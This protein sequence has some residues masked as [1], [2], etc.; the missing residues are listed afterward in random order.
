MIMNSGRVVLRE[1]G[2]WSRLVGWPVGW[3][4]RAASVGPC[5][6]WRAGHTSQRPAP[7]QPPLFRVSDAAILLSP[8]RR[9][10]TLSGTFSGVVV[11]SRLRWCRCAAA[12]V[13]VPVVVSRLRTAQICVDM[14]ACMQTFSFRLLSCRLEEEDDDA[15]AAA[16]VAYDAELHLAAAHQVHSSC[17]SIAGRWPYTSRVPPLQ[18][19]RLYVRQPLLWSPAMSR[20]RLWLHRLQSIEQQMQHEPFLPGILYGLQ[21]S[22]P[23]FFMANHTSDSDTA[24]TVPLHLRQRLLSQWTLEEASEYLTPSM[25]RFLDAWQQGER[26]PANERRKNAPG[27]FDPNVDTMESAAA[28]ALHMLGAVTRPE[29]SSQ[30]PQPLRLIM[31]PDGQQQLQVPE[32]RGL[33]TL[34]LTRGDSVVEHGANTSTFEVPVGLRCLEYDPELVQAAR[35]PDT[36]VPLLQLDHPPQLPVHATAHLSCMQAR[37]PPKLYRPERPGYVGVRGYMKCLLGM[38]GG[39]SYFEYAHRLVVWALLGPSNT[40]VLQS[41]LRLGDDSAA[42]RAAPPGQYSQEQLQAAEER[43]QKRALSAQQQAREQPADAMHICHNRQ[44]IH[45]WHLTWGLHIDNCSDRLCNAGIMHRTLLLRRLEVSTAHKAQCT[46]ALHEHAQLRLQL[47]GQSMANSNLFRLY[48]THPARNLSPELRYDLIIQHQTWTQ[49]Q[50][51]QALALLSQQQANDLVRLLQ[52]QALD[53]QQAMLLV[54]QQHQQQPA[55]LPPQPPAGP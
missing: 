15:A 20:H 51:Q 45:P 50:L 27:L 5:V 7:F 3:L 55:P 16:A 36:A 46:Q 25:A 19:G 32:P 18:Q 23:W 22:L 24:P 12:G 52:Q 49:Q 54:H 14:A 53:M 26:L 1:S 42:I 30:P 37:A 47:L 39:L 17:H 34:L 11:G 29:C 48:I 13:L 4:A 9:I 28:R 21:S 31:A 44:C 41:L 8:G 2:R 40:A 10:R 38:A 35:C 33:N 6:V 43:Q